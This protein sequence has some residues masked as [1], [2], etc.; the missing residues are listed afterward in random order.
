MLI[1]IPKQKDETFDFYS[2]IHSKLLEKFKT[3]ANT[4]KPVH[5]KTI[6]GFLGRIYHFDKQ[7]IKAVVN[8]LSL[9]GM[10]E[11]RKGSGLSNYFVVVKRVSIEP[12]N[13][14]CNF[15]KFFWL[16]ECGKNDMKCK[17]FERLEFY[18]K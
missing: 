2:N 8:D 3:E 13:H 16:G 14:N 15:C 6:N 11:I 7:T 9:R 17:N 4:Q 10:V 5:L 18:A 1:T 12:I